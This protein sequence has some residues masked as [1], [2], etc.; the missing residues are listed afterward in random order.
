M[1][2][3]A[4]SQ[5]VQEQLRRSCMSQSTNNI[6]TNNIINRRNQYRNHIS[7]TRNYN[8]TCTNNNN[9]GRNHYIG[10]YISHARNYNNT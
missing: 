7:H 4:N 3:P 8:N 1:K 5:Q 9:I 6:C 10:N 2:L